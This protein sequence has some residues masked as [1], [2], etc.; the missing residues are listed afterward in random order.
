MEIKLYTLG[1][2]KCRVLE[3]KLDK[4]SIEYTK[5]TD[6][7]LMIEIGIKSAPVLEIDGE[8]LPFAQA[9]AWVNSHGAK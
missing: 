9:I 2:P 8:K 4:A 5:V 7:D 3:Q 1:C 6:I